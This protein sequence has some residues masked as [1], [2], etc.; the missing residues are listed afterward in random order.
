MIDLERPWTEYEFIAFDTET[1]GAYPIGSEIVEFG[2]VKWKDGKET[3]RYQTLLKPSRPMSDFIIGIHGITNEMVADAPLMKDKIKEIREF[4]GES[5]LMAHHAPFDLGFV[6]ADFEKYKIAFPK[7]P[8]ICTSLVSRKVIHESPNH[9]LQTL[10]GVLGLER[11]SAHRAA[12]DANACLYVGLESMKRVGPQATLSQIMQVQGKM[13]YW[14]DYQLL[15]SGNELI[16]KVVE[17]LEKNL[18]MDIIYDGGS[19]SGGTRRITPMGIVRNPD[20]DYVMAKCHRD[21][22]QKRF[23]LQKIK[24]AVVAG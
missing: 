4:F 16:A 8:V 21:G 13:L 23:Y 24:D 22:A 1:S 10:I 6:A 3:G 17:S 9:K 5:V 19:N 18:P 2:A 7:N 20:G 12:D 11:G 14:N 15:G